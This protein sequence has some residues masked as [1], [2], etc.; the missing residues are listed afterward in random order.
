M[1]LNVNIRKHLQDFGEEYGTVS[2]NL[3]SNAKYMY[4][5]IIFQL[6]PINNDSYLSTERQS[7][8]NSQIRL[9]SQE[10]NRIYM[11]N[12]ILMIIMLLLALPKIAV[13]STTYILYIFRNIHDADVGW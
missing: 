8:L 12:K 7:T 2:Y 1:S 9:H 3:G 5:F 6:K 4:V 13:M 11:V 10:C